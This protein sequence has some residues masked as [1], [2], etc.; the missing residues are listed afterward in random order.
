MTGAKESVPI[1][2]GHPVCPTKSKTETRGSFGE[3]REGIDKRFAG[4][5]DGSV[6]K[7]ISGRPPTCL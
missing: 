5:S 6:S 7:I 1:D 4:N 2:V 3:K